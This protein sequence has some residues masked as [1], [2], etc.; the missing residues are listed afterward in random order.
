IFSVPGNSPF[1]NLEEALRAQLDSKSGKAIEL[2]KEWRSKQREAVLFLDRFEELFTLNPPDVQAHFIELIAKAALELNIRVLLSMRDDFLIRCNDFAQLATIFSELTPLSPLTG[3]SLRR[4]LVQPALKC[5]YRFEDE[6]LVD[7]ILSDV[8]KEKGA[9]PLMAFAAS[10]LWQKR[11][12]PSGRLTREA[13]KKIGG[14]AGALSQHAEA[15]MEKIGPDRQPIVREIFRNLITAENTRAGR[16]IDE[17]LSVFPERSA[18]E[19]V[20]RML[21]DARLLTSFEAPQAE[22]AKPSTQVE[23]VHESL[24]SHWPRLV[25]WQTQDADSAQLRDQLRQAAQVWEQR[26]R[27]DDLVWTGTAFLE[28]QAWRQRYPGGLTTTE[29][30]FAQAMMS[31]AHKR[32]RQRRLMVSAILVVLLIVLAVITIFWHQAAIAR[33]NAVLQARRAEAGKV[34][35]LGRAKAEADPS[36]KIAYAL[37]SLELNDSTEARRFA[38]QALSEGPPT[39]LIKTKTALHTVDFSPDGKWIA[40]STA[41]GV[42]LFPIDGSTP[43][44]VSEFGS[45]GEYTPWPIQFS[46]DGEFLLFSWRQDLSILKVWSMSQNKIVRTFHFEGITI[47]L[48]RAGKAFLITDTSGRLENPFKWNDTVVRVW[49]F[50]RREPEIVGHVKLGNII[51]KKFDID[52]R[53]QMLAYSKGHSVYFRP[54]DVSALGPEK[55]IGSQET[56]IETIKFR[57]TKQELA[58]ADSTGEIRIWSV[59]HQAQD[60]IHLIG[61]NSPEK[62]IWFDPNG[63]F[64]F[65]QG[66]GALLRWDLMVPKAEPISFKYLAEA[67]WSVTVDKNC[68]WLVA[69]ERTAIAFFPMTHSYPYI[70]RG[71]GIGNVIRFLQDGKSLVMDNGMQISNV[72]GETQLPSRTLWNSGQLKKA[73]EIDS[74]DVDPFGKY[75]LLGTA[76]DGVHLISIA[77]GKDLPLK[78][79]SPLEFPYYTPVALSPDANFAAAVR[80]GSGNDV[81]LEIWDLRSGTS[82]IMEKSRGIGMSTLK[83]SSDGKTLFSGD[84]GGKLYEWNFS[85]NSRQIFQIGNA[86]VTS[87]AVSNDRRYVAASSSSAKSGDNLALVTSDVVLYD[88]K[89]AKRINITSHGNRVCSV[90]FDVTGTKLLT[91]DLDGVLRVGS[92]TGETPHLL[93]GTER[94]VVNIAIQPGGNW[95]AANVGQDLRFWQMPEGIPFQNLSSVELADRLRGLT[96]LRIVSDNTIPNGYRLDYAPFPGWK[97]TPTW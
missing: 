97:K 21:I 62:V 25:R 48:V 46:P 50:D 75:A 70:F 73:I 19:E 89:E 72:P 65:T 12:R 88:L 17:L 82:R 9:L 94:R 30:A 24:L 51:W 36:T 76:G 87:I 6:K 45:S 2:L 60:A 68:R 42:Q 67:P 55:L 52:S 22:G 49:K 5:T 31:R 80:N 56:D 90:A 27:S 61:A 92:I 44:T 84:C 91:G 10:K 86:C 78:S 41:G 66:N 35:A 15:V 14:V 34:L 53:G 85:D 95:I 54:L 93:I 20:L 64:I 13:Y 18:S 26:S 29:E 69:A 33:D 8:E 11:D 81:G 32:R 79:N 47:C 16:D 63:S 38:M 57:P 59:F 43:T 39:L 3:A 23:I 77:D 40:G 4:A 83:Y 58:S 74:A 1:L 71:A 7:E 28:F 37:A 96:N